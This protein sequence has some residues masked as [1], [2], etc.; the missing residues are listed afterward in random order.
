MSNRRT[1]RRKN[2]SKDMIEKLLKSLYL[3]RKQTIELLPKTPPFSDDYNHLSELVDF[4]DSYQERYTGNPVGLI[5]EF[6][7]RYTGGFKS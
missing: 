7:E 1:T 2:L 3:T 4:I 6:S 5:D